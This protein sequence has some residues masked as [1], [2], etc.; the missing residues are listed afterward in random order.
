MKMSH[1]YELTNH[2]ATAPL[3]GKRLTLDAT[4]RNDM[5][6]HVFIAVLE[7][8]FSKESFLTL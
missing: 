2:E 3:N 6:W 8:N 5:K 1:G 4:K 7:K